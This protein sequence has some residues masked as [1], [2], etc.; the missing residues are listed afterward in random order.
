M[1]KPPP[2]MTVEWFSGHTLYDR[3]RRL[4]WSGQ[5]LDVVSVLQRGYT[6]DGAFIK[7]IASNHSFFLLNYSV[8][9][10]SWHIMPLR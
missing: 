9:S 10:D 2:H 8:H 7:I 1:N 4:F 3:P 6:P 5:W